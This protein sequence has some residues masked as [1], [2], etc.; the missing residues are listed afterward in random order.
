LNDER[1]TI[2]LKEYEALLDQEINDCFD[3]FKAENTIILVMLQ[4][5][6]HMENVLGRIIGHALPAGANC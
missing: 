3:P 4:F 5:H 1:V 2:L 6:L